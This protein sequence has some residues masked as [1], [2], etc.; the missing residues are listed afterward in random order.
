MEIYFVGEPISAVNL[1]PQVWVDELCADPQ[2]NR[3]KGGRL[4]LHFGSISIY[5][6]T[7]PGISNLSPE[8]LGSNRGVSRS[9]VW[10]HIRK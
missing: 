3:L 7:V 2:S 9:R 1:S 8:L 6:L 10:H 5:V 4:V